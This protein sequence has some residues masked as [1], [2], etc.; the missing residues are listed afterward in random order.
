[1]IKTKDLEGLIEHSLTLNKCSE[2][3]V[4]VLHLAWGDFDE[5][6]VQN[7]PKIDYLIGSDV[8][9]DSK[10]TLN[11]LNFFKTSL[12]RIFNLSI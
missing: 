1:M 12:K 3:N 11:K 8:F 9:F 4:K 10:C 6:F 5:N 2:N 7:L